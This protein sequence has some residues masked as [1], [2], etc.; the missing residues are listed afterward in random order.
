MPVRAG[1]IRC[2][3]HP[4]GNLCAPVANRLG[5]NIVLFERCVYGLLS[6]RSKLEPLNGY[7]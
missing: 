7:R 1:C 4:T 6:T 2:A 3:A 5:P